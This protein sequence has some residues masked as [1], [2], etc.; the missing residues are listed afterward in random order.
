[1]DARHLS[2][3]LLRVASYVPEDA[4]LADIGSDHAYLPAYL[5]LNNQLAFA[6]AG[7][8]VEG[9]YQNAVNEIKEEGLNN[10]IKVRHADGLAAI[11][12]EDNINVITICG[13]GGPLISEILEEGQSKLANHPLLILQPNV[14]EKQ[15]RN[16]LLTNSYRIV[17]EEILSE[18][19]HIYEIIVAKYDKNAFELSAED[20]EFGPFL[21]QQKNKVFV[22]K[23]QEELQKIKYVLEEM[24]KA[25]EFPVAQEQKMLAKIKRIEG[26]L[27]D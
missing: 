27:D 22:A 9:P 11:N 10:L 6:I 15:V 16:W 26:I 20:L 24:K 12:I 17:A 5:G 14:G 21:R 25:R 23:W 7:E 4:R 1:M 19:H 3:R 2:Q 8:V 13:M 18:D